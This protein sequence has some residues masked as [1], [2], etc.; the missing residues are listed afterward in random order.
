LRREDIEAKATEGDEGDATPN[1]LL[2]HP[3]ETFA[4]YVRKELKHLQHTSETLEKRLEKPLQ[5]ICN[6]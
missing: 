2:K 6:I 4:T 5:N 3:N 1:L